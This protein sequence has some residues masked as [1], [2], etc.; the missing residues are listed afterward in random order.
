MWDLDEIFKKSLVI[1]GH[2]GFVKL[3]NCHQ[4]IANEYCSF[5]WT[6]PYVPIEPRDTLI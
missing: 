2:G 1:D 3:T 5:A 4:T 6:D